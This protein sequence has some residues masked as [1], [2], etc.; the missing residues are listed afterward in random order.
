[1]TC[2][3]ERLNASTTLRRVLS[4]AR[5]ITCTEV[6]N[7]RAYASWL[8]VVF[9]W[10]P[11]FL[12]HYFS[13]VRRV[14]IA[15]LGQKINLG[16]SELWYRGPVHSAAE[17]LWC[18]APTNHDNNFL[19]DG[20]ILCE[21]QQD[22]RCCNQFR[23]CCALLERAHAKVWILEGTEVDTG[24]WDGILRKAWPDAWEWGRWTSHGT[25]RILRHKQQD[26]GRRSQSTSPSL[27]GKRRRKKITLLNWI[28]GLKMEGSLYKEV[29]GSIWHRTKRAQNVGTL[30]PRK[31]RG[32]DQCWQMRTKKS[33]MEQTTDGNKSRRKKKSWNSSGRAVAC[34]LMV[35]CCAE[36]STRRNQAIG[37][38]ILENSWKRA[39]LAYGQV[40]RWENASMKQNQ[41]T[42]AV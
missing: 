7:A 28:H 26:V 37:G 10:T 27:Q 40:W 41:K 5:N 42:K 18:S 8:S 9:T 12:V 35:Y 15:N 23:H 34:V 22:D 13:T 1:M 6:L 32:P 2:F 36:H 21:I 4:H 11:I 25:W 29:V 31:R 38:V 3:Y 17:M 39:G 19:N 24:W 20:V 14:H 33:K 16:S 30:H